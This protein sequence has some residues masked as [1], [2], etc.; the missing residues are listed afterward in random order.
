MLN[1]MNDC[2]YYNNSI[3][4]SCGLINLTAPMQLKEKERLVVDAL[5]DRGLSLPILPCIPSD[6]SFGS[7]NKAK[8]AVGD[9]VLGIPKDLYSVADI[10]ECPL[11]LDAPTSIVGILATIKRLVLPSVPHYSV[12]DRSGELKF[13][14]I[15]ASEVTGDTILRFVVRSRDAEDKFRQLVPIL[16][17]QHPELKVITLNIQPE[18]KAILEGPEEVYLTQ[19]RRIIDSIGQYKFIHSPQ[20]FSQVTHN[21]ALKLY[22]L[23][24]DEAERC[25]P[26]A[27]LDVY[28]GVGTFATF[29][30]P[31]ADSVTGVEVV[32]D[33]VN[34]AKASA[35]INGIKNISF[36]ALDIDN[37]LDG[38]QLSRSDFVIVNPPRRGLSSKLIKALCLAQPKTLVYSSCNPETLARDL[39]QLVKVFDVSTVQPLD[40]FP[41]Q[42]HVETLVIMK[43]R[44]V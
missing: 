38:D 44:V 19:S 22:Q 4:Q 28:C 33:A 21:V 6:K 27:G 30:S 41:M 43:S 1:R 5:S 16:Q 37:W 42:P 20:S 18:H 13:C 34:D 14:I 40:M 11:L 32:A 9:G 17:E 10:S 36:H 23:L 7:R 12:K 15:R 26:K 2:N 25:K 3:C 8:F 31:F 35:D 39:S 29:I 24:A